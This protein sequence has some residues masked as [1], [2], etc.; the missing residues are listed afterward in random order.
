MS[1]QKQREAPSVQWSPGGQICFTSGSAWGVLKTGQTAC[2]GPAGD[3]EGALEC[4]KHPTP[5]I[6]NIIQTDYNVRAAV[7][8]R[9]ALETRLRRHRAAK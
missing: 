3:I 4:R 6:Q 2:L 9:T 5:V 7:G 8:S 1:D